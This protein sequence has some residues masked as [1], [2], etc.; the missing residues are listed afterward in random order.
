MALKRKRL[1][2]GAVKILR[3]ANQ[4]T[5]PG[6]GTIMESAIYFSTIRTTSALQKMAWLSVELPRLGR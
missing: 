4:R 2:N 5:A 3:V 1:A 6:L